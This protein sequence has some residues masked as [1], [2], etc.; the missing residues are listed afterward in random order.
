MTVNTLQITFSDLQNAAYIIMDNK[1]I[2]RH[3]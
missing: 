1:F 3:A 2:I